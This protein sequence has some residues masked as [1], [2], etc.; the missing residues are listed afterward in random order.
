MNKRKD[1][2]LYSALLFLLLGVSVLLTPVSA[3]ASTAVLASYENYK[4]YNVVEYG[5]D[6]TGSRA[7]ERAINLAVKQALSDKKAGN[8]DGKQNVA[9]Y[10]PSGQYTLNDRVRVTSNIAIIAESDSIVNGSGAITLQIEGADSI[11]DG[12]VW[13]NSNPSSTT[14]YINHASNASLLNLSTMSGGYGI[15]LRDCTATLKNI[16]VWNAVNTGMALTLQSVVKADGIDVRYNGTGFPKKGYGHGIGLWNNSDLTI[17]N[18]SI[19]NNRQCGISM[20]PGTLNISSSKIQ[21]NGRNG[22]GTK[23][24]CNVTMYQCEIYEN[25]FYK[26]SEQMNGVIIVDGSYARIDSCIFSTNAVSGLLVT[27]KGSYVDLSNSIFKKNGYN[28]IYMEY[29]GKS[30]KVTVNV[31]SCTFYATKKKLDSIK[32]HAKSKKYFRLSLSNSNTYKSLKYKKT[33]WIGN[34][35]KRY[36][37]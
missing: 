32:V 4:I 28:N 9:V 15:K 8:L 20:N 1:K 19:S 36:G 5:A 13:N 2:V 24:K 30:G 35:V 34:S 25:G 7:C 31:Q 22:I 11:V 26:K 12:G 21:K 16:K 3:S 29:M 33:Y 17:T 27:G 18:S 6:P 37:V 14:I 10:I 23:G